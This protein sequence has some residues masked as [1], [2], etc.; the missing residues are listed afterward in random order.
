MIQR[1]FNMATLAEEA[2]PLLQNRRESNH[3]YSDADEIERIRSKDPNAIIIDFDQHHD[4]DPEN[5]MDWPTAYKWS[6]VSLLA[7]MAFTV[8][9]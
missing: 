5:P 8:Y 4:G 3:Q 2:A 6:I 7:F 9:V 1:S